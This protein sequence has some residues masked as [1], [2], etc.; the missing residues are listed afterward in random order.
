MMPQRHLAAGAEHLA[1]SIDKARII[2]QPVNILATNDPHRQPLAAI[3]AGDA[4]GAPASCAWVAA[5]SRSRAAVR[6][7]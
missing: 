4:P 2:K 6:R 5:S 1:Q 7:R 3:G